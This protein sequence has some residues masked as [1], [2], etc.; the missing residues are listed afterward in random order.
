[1]LVAV[2]DDVVVVVV[3][4][5]VVEVVVME[6]VEVTVAVKV[7]VGAV[8]VVVVV[9]TTVTVLVGKVVMTV[10]LL[11]TVD[12]HETVDMD[13]WVLY[14]T[15][16]SIMVVKH[17]ELCGNEPIQVVVS[18]KPEIFWEHSLGAASPAP[19]NNPHVSKDGVT[20]RIVARRKERTRDGT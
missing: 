14:G 3:T 2:T 4:D 13:H 15:E 16:L 12:V 17:C 9:V 1:M 10:V 18:P 7:L 20:K 6:E 19:A 11:V 5:T 8:V